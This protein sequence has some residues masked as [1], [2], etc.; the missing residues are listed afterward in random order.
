VTT[1]PAPVPTRASVSSV[2]RERPVIAVLRANDPGAYDAVVDVL[3]ENGIRSIELTLTTPGTLEHLSSLLER[4]T[5]AEIGVGT[6]TTVDEALCAIDAGAH[7]LVTPVLDTAVIRVAVEAGIPVYPGALTPTEV[8][9]AWQAGAA[10]VKIFP[11]ETVGAQYGTHLRGPF[12][13]IEFIPSGGVALDDIPAW[14]QAGAA[15]VS[16]GGPLIG[17]ALKG[18]SLEALANRCRRV[19]AIVEQEAR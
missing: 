10:A 8:F 5:D 14:L 13:G 7:Y 11:A 16:L 19:V 2:L 6:V 15:A 9:A 12:P 18:G 3:V 1:T 17:D 4:F